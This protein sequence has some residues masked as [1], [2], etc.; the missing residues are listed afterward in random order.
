MIYDVYP[1]GT[2]VHYYHTQTAIVFMR[3]KKANIEYKATA[4]TTTLTKNITVTMKLLFSH[5]HRRMSECERKK[6]IEKKEV[7]GQ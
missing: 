3:E 2:F 4:T 7:S 6:R 5:L 1:F